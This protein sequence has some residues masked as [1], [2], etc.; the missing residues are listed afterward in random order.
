MVGSKAGRDD[1]D[2]GT[3]T[4]QYD[5]R[6]LWVHREMAWKPMGRPAA[7][8]SY[9]TAKQQANVHLVHSLLRQGSRKEQVGKVVEKVGEKTGL[10]IGV[11]I[12]HVQL[13]TRN[14]AFG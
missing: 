4:A 14:P 1:D 12:L 13:D 8:S 10:V 2:A 11:I 7:Y 3:T 6:R 9:I 5:E